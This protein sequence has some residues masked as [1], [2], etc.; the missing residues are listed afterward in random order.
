MNYTEC[1]KNLNNCYWVSGKCILPTQ[2]SDFNTQT[3][4]Q[5]I[6]SNSP[7]EGKCEWNES[8]KKCQRKADLYGLCSQN[9]DKND[10]T[11]SLLGCAWINNKCV[12]AHYCN[13]LSSSVCENL[14]SNTILRSTCEWNIKTKKCQKDADEYGLCSDNN[15]ENDCTRSLLG[16]AWINNKCVN[17]HYCNLLS[18]SVCENLMSNTILRS[19]CE[20]NIKTKKCQKDAD[21][22]GLCSDNNNENDCTRSLLGCAWVNNTCVDAHYC[23]LLSSSVCGNLIS[24]TILR[25]T[26]EWN[27]N[28]KKCQ[29]EADEYGLCSDNN[30]ENDCT[31]SLL[32][33]AWINNTCIDARYCSLLS[34]SVCENLMSNTVLRSTCTWNKND[35]ICLPKNRLIRNLVEDEV[36][37]KYSCSFNFPNINENKNYDLTLI[38][39]NNNKASISLSL[40]SPPSDFSSEVNDDDNDDD[41]NYVIYR[42]SGYFLGNTLFVSLILILFLYLF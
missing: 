27:E 7:F 29:K 36:T 12:N 31:R 35:N 41:E 8:T 11:R 21:E 5:N 4:C 20:W 2:C 17:A 25:S 13:L 28:T 16:C 39:K 22:Y 30:N 10:C 18:S 15:N 34:S 42:S 14:M 33:C 9:L 38:D 37:T 3:V 26:C 40:I 6:N 19:T 24:N 1:Q 32:G 23:N